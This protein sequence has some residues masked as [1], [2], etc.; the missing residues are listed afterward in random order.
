MT[1]CEQEVVEEAVRTSS[2]RWPLTTAPTSSV[3]CTTTRVT[4]SY[5][6]HGGVSEEVQRVP[7]VFWS[8]PTTVKSK[9]VGQDFQTPDILPTILRAIGIP[10][11]FP[12]DGH[13]RNL[14]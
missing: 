10:L 4:G 13:S 8:S 1:K 2:T 14:K 5:G 7:M 3:C 9:T 12:V 11:T 6:D